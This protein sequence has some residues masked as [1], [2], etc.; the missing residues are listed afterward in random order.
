MITLHL[1][2]TEK[3]RDKLLCWYLS[4]G[5]KAL[6]DLSQI[7]SLFCNLFHGYCKMS[8]NKSPRPDGVCPGVQKQL[9]DE[10]VEL[11]ML[12]ILLLD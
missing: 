8:S 1:R 9:K 7:V 12:S 6:E 3:T 10:T 11:L 5:K 2:F 4:L